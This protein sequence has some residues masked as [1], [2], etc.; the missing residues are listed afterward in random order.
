MCYTEFMENYFNYELTYDRM[1]FE[2]SDSPS[3]AERE[4]HS[5]HELLFCENT[6]VILRTEDRQTEISGSRIL[7]IP[8][9]KYHLFDLPCGRPFSRL[10][11]SL[12]DELVSGTPIKL[13]SGGILIFHPDERILSIVKRL[14]EL[15]NCED[16]A[17]RAYHAYHAAMM[18][19]CEL[20]MTAERSEGEGYQENN[21]A[22]LKI[23]DY[24]SK[25][26]SADLSVGELSRVVNFSPSFLLHKFREE[27]GISLHRYVTE[28]R[29][30]YAKSRIDSGARPT[31]VYRECGYRDY[32]SFYKA[33]LRRF[34]TAPSE[35]GRHTE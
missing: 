4:I 33:Y 27:M 18:L 11:I 22:V 26:L 5:Y 3:I 29:M 28:K 23:I 25:N 32:S 24:I 8:R 19:L 21:L 34:A 10:K 9:G 31:E 14:C 6:Q 16:N 35:K 15:V 2:L 7:I 13:F 30:S 20:E 1:R 17:S 12:P